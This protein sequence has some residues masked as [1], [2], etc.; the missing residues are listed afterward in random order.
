VV[1]TEAYSSYPDDEYVHEF[2]GLEPAFEQAG[3]EAFEAIA[4]QVADTDVP[5]VTEI[6]HG[7]PQEEIL[8]YVDE[9]DIGLT[10]VGLKNRS[11][12]YRRL[13]GSDAERVAQLSER[14]VTIGKMPVEE[15]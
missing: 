1:D 13:L 14:P 5:T 10:V 8:A 4:Q 3:T 15:G 9:A 6:R 12:K 7:M 11:G 2:E